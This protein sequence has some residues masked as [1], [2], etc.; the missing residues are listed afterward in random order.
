MDNEL[1]LGLLMSRAGS[2]I[3]ELSGSIFHNE[4]DS[5]LKN[6]LTRLGSLLKEK[7]SARLDSTHVNTWLDSRA[8]ESAHEPAHITC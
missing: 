7:S 1:D 5:K 6:A 4:S 8:R 3:N 2:R